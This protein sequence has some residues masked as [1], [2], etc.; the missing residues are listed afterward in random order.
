LK[1]A[2]AVM[3]RFPGAYLRSVERGYSESLRPSGDIYWVAKSKSD[4][5]NRLSD[6][7]DLAICGQTNPRVDRAWHAKEAAAGSEP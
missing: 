1:D 2:V 3:R 7:W 5:M 4:R 6:I